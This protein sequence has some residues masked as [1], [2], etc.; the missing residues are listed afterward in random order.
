MSSNMM[1]IES[2][3]DQ[4]KGTRM[5]REENSGSIR[6]L[7]IPE[8]TGQRSEVVDDWVYLAE[9]NLNIAGVPEQRRVPL[10]VSRLREEALSWFR[11]IEKVHQVED[12]PKLKALLLQRYGPPNRQHDLRKKLSA[13]KQTAAMEVYVNEFLRILAHVEDMHERDKIFAFTNGLSPKASTAV[14]MAQVTS[15]TEA[16]RVA[17]TFETYNMGEQRRDQEDRNSSMDIDTVGGFRGNSKKD[18][19]CF[20]CGRKGHMKK[21]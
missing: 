8:F 2:L 10:V 15:L 6:R 19:R 11:A 5:D 4:L 14:G 3:T 17:Q 18:F 16:I 1:N 12:W 20:K 7:D 13:L 21:D 9:L